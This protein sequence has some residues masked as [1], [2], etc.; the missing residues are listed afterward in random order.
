MQWNSKEGILITSS[1]V[2]VTILM[3]IFVQNSLNRAIEKRALTIGR[4]KSEIDSF[5]SLVSRSPHTVPEPTQVQPI[6]KSTVQ[7]VV[8]PPPIGSGKKWTPL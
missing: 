8:Q 6:I 2:I 7:P 4:S 5:S 3:T 1:L